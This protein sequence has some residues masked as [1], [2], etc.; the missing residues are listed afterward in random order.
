LLYA[1]LTW[2]RRSKIG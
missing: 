1:W 2:S